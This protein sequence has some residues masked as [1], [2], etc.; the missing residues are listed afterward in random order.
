[1]AM[2]FA[3]GYSQHIELPKEKYYQ[4]TFTA[5]YSY[6]KD[7]LKVELKNPLNCPLRISISSPDTSLFDIVARFSNLTLKEK[8]DTIITYYLKNRNHIILRFNSVVGDVGKE[9]IKEKFSLPF[10]PNRTYKIIQGYNGWHSH[11]SNNSRYAID[12]SLKIGDT[13]CSAADGYVVGVIKDYKLGG[14]AIAWLDYANFITIYHP[15]S[16]LF[17]QYV[18]LMNNGSFVKVGDTVR[19]G[20]P[21][22]L[23]GMTGYTTVSHLHFNVLQPDKN[24]GWVSTNIDFEEGYKGTE[25][26]ENTTVKK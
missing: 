19:K 26:T 13:V 9:I 14:T 22:A 5:K 25:L 21:I 11:N 1:M 15:Q 6:N 10:P 2:R 24:Q 20:Q 18:H 16:G 17:T 23:S 7:S 12:F 4:F 3:I 8:S